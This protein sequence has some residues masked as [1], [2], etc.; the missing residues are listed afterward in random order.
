MLL[1][2]A[3]MT[4]ATATG[5]GQSGGPGAGQ[6]LTEPAGDRIYH[7]AYPD[8][9]DA[10]QRVRA[11]PVRRFERLAG[12]RLAWVYFS[13][14]W[15]RGRIRFPGEAV[16]RIAALGRTP[17]IRLM[18]RSNWGHGRDPNFSMAS[19]AGGQWDAEL[20]AWCGAAAAAIEELDTPLLAEFGTEVN[21]DWFP[22][23]GRWNGG[24]RTDGYGDPAAPDGPERFR[25]AY[26]RIVDT[27]RAQGASDITWFF[28]VDA[29]SSPRAGWNTDYSNYYPGDGY[30]DWLGLSAYGALHTDERARDLS[31]RVD[32]AYP[33]LAAVAPGKPIA[34]LDTGT[35]KVATP[36]ARQ[37][38]SAVRCGRSCP[39]AGPGS[40]PSPT[41]A[42]NGATTTARSRTCGST[43]R[44]GPCARTAAAPDA[45]R[46]P[47]GRASRRASGRNRDRR[48]PRRR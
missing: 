4:L 47:A 25:D 16:E 46:S 34:I 23:N 22:W 35:P 12:R 11:A 26:R 6:V 20:E 2:A 39:G 19:I 24:G 7:A 48:G 45:G 28:H 43:R 36:A 29:G 1:G 10:E 30:I 41:G 37:A 8:F 33:R 5:A 9:G 13:N 44:G 3:G 14:N 15:W 18:A 32:R 17:F 31:A 42:S 40:A 38:G 27:C 21:G